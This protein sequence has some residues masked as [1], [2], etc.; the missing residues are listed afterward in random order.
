MRPFTTLLFL[1]TVSL[2]IAGCI[3]NWTPPPTPHP[4]VNSAPFDRDLPAEADLTTVL[5]RGDTVYFFGGRSR[6]GRAVDSVW[7]F[8]LGS[9]T[10]IARSAMPT[11]RYYAA[12]VSAGGYIYV[13]GGRDNTP[14]AELAARL[15]RIVERYDPALDEWTALPDVTAEGF[16][17]T[18]PTLATAARGR[19]YAIGTIRTSRECHLYES[20]DG[21]TWRSHR[22]PIEPSF[23]P[24]LMSDG[25]DLLLMTGA[26]AFF[27]MRFFRIDAETKRTE[28]DAPAYP[29]LR[30]ASN[31]W[32]ESGGYVYNLNGGEGEH[33]VVAIY[34][35]PGTSWAFNGIPYDVT[36][37]RHFVPIVTDRGLGTLY[38]FAPPQLRIGVH[39]APAENR[40]FTR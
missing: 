16:E 21:V 23:E 10:W 24:T 17:V 11:A 30:G 9:R 13:I 3:D 1:V 5:Q 19:M 15:P 28:L 7:A 27:G 40:F 33:D 14:D 6:T 25:R 37:N 36:S 20:T 26:E 18:S 29:W 38:F 35:S 22:L 8:V 39:Y 31:R 4:P 2:S 12:A 34:D 32:I